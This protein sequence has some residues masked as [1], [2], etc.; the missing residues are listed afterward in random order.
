IPPQG[1]S[2]DGGGGIN[3]VTLKDDSLIDATDT[4]T[5]A[6]SGSISLKGP[7]PFAPEWTILYS[8]VH[9]LNDVAAQPPPFLLNRLTFNATDGD[10]AIHVV[11]GPAVRGFVTTQISSSGTFATLNFA[12]RQDVTVNTV[13]GYDQVE[14]NDPNPETALRTVTVNTD[15][16]NGVD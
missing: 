15:V 3:S 6:A 16:G 14:L 5:G 8:N 2:F 13:D 7:S 4:A 11:D 1:I 9:V 12:N 10:D